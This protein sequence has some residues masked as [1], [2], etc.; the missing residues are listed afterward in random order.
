M[1][2]IGV[3]PHKDAHQAV[4]VTQGGKQ[5]ADC[6]VQ[7][8]KDGFDTLLAWGRGIAADVRLWVIEDCRHVSG[9]QE[10]FLIDH[11]PPR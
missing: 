6:E 7:A 10:R 11:V 2:T 3:D 9:P 4:A 1:V 8:A 5:L